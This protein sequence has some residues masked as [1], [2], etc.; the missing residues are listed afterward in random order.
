MIPKESVDTAVQILDFL[1]T[2]QGQIIVKIG[3]V[4]A[5]SHFFAAQVV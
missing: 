2:P 1:N 4:F 5:I 3:G